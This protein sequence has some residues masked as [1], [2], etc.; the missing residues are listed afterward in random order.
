MR[1]M[2]QDKIILVFATSIFC[3]VPLTNKM[4][5]LKKIL[6]PLMEFKISYL[7]PPNLEILTTI[8]GTLLN[9]KAFEEHSSRLTIHIANALIDQLKVVSSFGRVQ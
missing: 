6:I 1:R 3:V 5:N 2:F 8:G 7:N 9:H 4:C